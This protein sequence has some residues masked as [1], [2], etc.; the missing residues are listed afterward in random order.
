[1][2]HISVLSLICGIGLFLSSCNWEQDVAPV[3]TFN[4]V[5]NMTIAE[6]LEYHTI[7]STNSFDSIPAG[8]IISGIV[9]SSDEHGNCYKFINIE[10]G[11]AGI[12]I[13]IDN[14]TLYHKYPVGQRVF[15]KCDGLVLG[16]YYKLPQLGMWENG[17]M[18]GI[19]SSKTSKYIFCDG[20]PINMEEDFTPLVLN[21][22]PRAD[23]VPATYYN[24]LVKLENATFVEGGAATYCEPN[25]STSHDIKMSDGTTITMRTSNYADFINEMLPVGTGTIYGILTR[26]NNYV[27][28]VI[29]DLDDVQGFVVPQQTQTIF[30]VNYNTAFEDGWIHGSNWS[31]LSNSSFTGFFYNGSSSSNGS[32]LISPAINLSEVTDPTLTF[33]HRAPQGFNSQK[34]MCFYTPA[35]TGDVNTSLWIPLN[36]SAAEGENAFVNEHVMLPEGAQTANFRIAFKAMGENVQWAI[37]NITIT[38]LAK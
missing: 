16:D 7:G 19:P 36:L 2:K 14:S 34:M 24:R 17:S 30:S 28:I 26:Y 10:D 5:A 29:R 31:I 12:Q 3:P 23:N 25:T 4:G 37:N 35:Y 9:V 1:M 38:G 18:Q 8:T 27:Q 6:L 33:T 22:I 15:V 20:T 13:K 21:S 11:T 32:W